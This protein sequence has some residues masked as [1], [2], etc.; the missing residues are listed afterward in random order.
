MIQPTATIGDLDEEQAAVVGRMRQRSGG[1]LA[2]VLDSDGWVREST[3]V[4][5]AGDEPE[6]RLR[7]L[8]QDGL[9]ILGVEHNMDLV[10]T[11]A[12]RVL[13]IDYGQHLF[14]GA[15][16]QVQQHPGVIAAYLG[17]ERPKGS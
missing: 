6:E 2:F 15:P 5:G 14:E 16:A 4:P 8:R 11:I 12:D 10:M 1:A 17:E 7:M 3:D 13:V 9:T